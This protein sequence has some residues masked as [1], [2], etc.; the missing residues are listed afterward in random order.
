MTWRCGWS[1]G[2]LM[3][4]TRT[5]ARPQRRKAARQ[6]A[7]SS[8]G[9]V[10]QWAAPRFSGC[11]EELAGSFG[12]RLPP[13]KALF[14]AVEAEVLCFGSGRERQRSAHTV[15]LVSALVR[16]LRW[17]EEAPVSWQQG[18]C[19]VL[20]GWLLARMCGLG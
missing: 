12:L 14:L 19:R 13:L 2:C 3:R 6:K 15:E 18:P 1:R 20:A 11:T 7:R 8:Q 4:I 16:L 17:P 9:W 5:R 10:R